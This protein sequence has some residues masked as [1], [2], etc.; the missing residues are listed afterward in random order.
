MQKSKKQSLRGIFMGCV[1]GVFANNAAYAEDCNGRVIMGH[2][3]YYGKFF[4]N[5]TTANGEKFN[6]YA[7]TAAHKTL[8]FG[9]KVEVTLPETG[10]T[11]IVRIN[12]RGPFI[13]G[14]DIDLSQN[15]AMR[16]GM[17]EKGVARVRMQLCVR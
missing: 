16:L 11:V 14:R 6:M 10:K 15:A 5:K 2:A 3:S 7:M 1:A 4:H 12:D 17:L 8:P 9:T 13:K